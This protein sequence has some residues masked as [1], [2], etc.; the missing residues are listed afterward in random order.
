VAE[1][2]RLRWFPETWLHGQDLKRPPDTP[3]EP[4]QALPV[5]SHRDVSETL[6]A[7]SVVGAV[8]PERIKLRDI[9]VVAANLADHAILD[10]HELADGLVQDSACMLC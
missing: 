7:S 9:R 5:A 3:D 4:P 6:P 10:L 8:S 1:P 2:S